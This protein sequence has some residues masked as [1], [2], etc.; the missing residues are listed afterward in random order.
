MAWSERGFSR[1]KN[2][3][4]GLRPLYLHREDHIVGLVRL[5]SLA[6]R[7]LTLVEFVVRRELQAHD[8]KLA[9]LYEGNP[10]RQT[11]RPTT[12]R[13]LRAFGNISL[14]LVNLPGQKFAHLTPLTPLQSRILSLLGLSPSIYTA[15]AITNNPISP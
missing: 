7:L 6:L 15:L 13:L 2:R 5:L 12:E 1:L 3:P 11:N 9:G 10:N 14:T 8:E 4:L